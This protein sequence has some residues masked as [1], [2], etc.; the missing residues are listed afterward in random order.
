MVKPGSF[1]VFEGIDGSGKSTQVTRLVEALRAA[2]HE[3]EATFEP[4]RG[5]FGRKIREK[6]RAGEPIPPETELSWFEED[7]KSH[8]EE[9]IQPALGAGKV[10]V[11]D[12]YYLSTVAYQGARGLPWREILERSESLFPA[13]DLVLLLEIDPARSQGRLA[14]R[15]GP[16]EPDFENR[17]FQERVA[18]IFKELH[19]PYLERIDGEADADDV[20]RS[21]RAAVAH[22]LGLLEEE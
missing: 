9:M 17:D 1:I 21:V 10:V 3:A 14:D 16:A 19:F 12:R 7:R 20:E 6:A 4:T 5:P 18:E 22:R 8:V 2:G 11:C 15:G 13:P